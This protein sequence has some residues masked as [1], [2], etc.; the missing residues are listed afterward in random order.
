M[1]NDGPL[2]AGCR[3]SQQSVS[4]PKRK[5][6]RTLNAATYCSD[7]FLG[8]TAEQMPQKTP[9]NAARPQSGSCALL[10]KAV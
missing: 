1:T 7:F 10:K 2:L 5:I 8:H 4:N 6:K 3:L 9:T